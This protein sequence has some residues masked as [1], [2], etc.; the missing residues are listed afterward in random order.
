[1]EVVYSE[2]IREHMQG[3][4]ALISVILEVESFYF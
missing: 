3:T 4:A 1:M 2:L